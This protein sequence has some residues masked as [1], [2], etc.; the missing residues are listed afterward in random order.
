[1]RHTMNFYW[2]YGVRISF[3]RY[4]TLATFR[5][6]HPDWEIRLWQSDWKK[7]ALAWNFH[8][9]QSRFKATHDWSKEA[10]DLLGVKMCS[11][12]PA[13]E[14]VLGFAPPNISDIFSYET[15]HREGGW[16][17]DMDILFTKNFDHISDSGSYAWMGFGDMED[18]VGI[19]GCEPGS[20][21]MKSFYDACLDNYT[22]EHYNSTGT[23]GIIKSCTSD[24]N[25]C[26]KFAEGDRGL[27]NWRCPR[28]MF[29]PLRPQHTSFLYSDSWPT[30]KPNTWAVHL[31]GGNQDFA[32]WNR[33]LTPEYLFD[34]AHNEWVC[35][36]V[37][38]E[39]KAAPGLIPRATPKDP[40]TVLVPNIP[41]P[42]IPELE[43][44]DDRDN[45]A[46]KGPVADVPAP[47]LEQPAED[48]V[49]PEPGAVDGGGERAGLGDDRVAVP[50]PGGEPGVRVDGTASPGSVDEL[51]V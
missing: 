45:S 40:E 36:F 6:W 30:P 1:M 43:V 15:L 19:F 38:D 28:D 4:L 49:Q 29:Y 39:L 26:N 37:R 2:S 33:R 14:R 50:A 22:G 44:K 32:I 9:F 47:V 35:R 11:Y 20:W 3:Y 5:H 7:T 12:V 8:E 51:G 21:V 41:P 13:D 18:W 23:Q 31:F 10:V 27:K 25:W 16:Y 48:R 42:V 34:N 17:A 46:D 24:I